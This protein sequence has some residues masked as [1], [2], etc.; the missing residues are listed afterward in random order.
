[1]NPGKFY[2]I[3]EQENETK[4]NTYHDYL[5]KKKNTSKKE[6]Q[7]PE[8]LHQSEFEL[9]AK[10]SEVYSDQF[11]EHGISPIRTIPSPLPKL[12]PSKDEDTSP[13]F[14]RNREQKRLSSPI[15]VRYN[16][17]KEGSEE[18]NFASSFYQKFIGKQNSKYPLHIAD[19]SYGWRKKLILKQFEN[20]SSQSQFQSNKLN[21]PDRRLIFSSEKQKKQTKYINNNNN[22]L[23]QPKRDELSEI[24]NSIDMTDLVHCMRATT[25]VFN[26]P[27]K[28]NRDSKFKKLMNKKNQFAKN[29]NKESGIEKIELTLPEIKTNLDKESITIKNYSKLTISRKNISRCG[30]KEQNHQQ[31]KQIEFEFKDHIKFSNHKLQT[32]QGSKQTNNRNS[33]PI[34]SS[35]MEFLKI[36]EKSTTNGNVGKKM[37]TQQH[38]NKKMHEK[39]KHTHEVEDNLQQQ[40]RKQPSSKNFIDIFTEKNYLSPSS[41]TEK[42]TSTYDDVKSK[43]E[44]NQPITNSIYDWKI[45]QNNTPTNEIYYHQPTNEKYQNNK[46]ENEMYQNDKVTKEPKLDNNP[47]NEGKRNNSPMNQPKDENYKHVKNFDDAINALNNHV[48]QLNQR[49]EL[50]KSTDEVY[51]LNNL[52]DQIQKRINSA[53]LPTSPRMNHIFYSPPTTATKRK[54]IIKNKDNFD[55]LFDNNLAFELGRRVSKYFNFE[56]KKENKDDY[57]VE[58]KLFKKKMHENEESIEHEIQKNRALSVEHGIQILSLQVK[59]PRLPLQKESPKPF[60]PKS[61]QINVIKTKIK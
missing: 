14:Y 48:N 8:D 25:H 32:F 40:I 44:K 9:P 38:D 11:E 49:D 16:Q 55:V 3:N 28:S 35:K 30:G 53:S 50:S 41:L 5:L 17:L 19:D 26:T 6:Q 43:K 15:V 20:E 58:N 24:Q 46:P 29:Y 13:V 59:I 37:T 2:F 61:T 56:K 47:Q 12:I 33:R 4:N 31:Q 23:Q 45:Y 52:I 60:R 1:M 42:N 22:N 27:Q 18:T 57:N 7:I 51:N 10:N 34:S 39:I 36:Q 54:T 21:E